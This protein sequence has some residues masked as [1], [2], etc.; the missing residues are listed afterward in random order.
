MLSTRHPMDGFSADRVTAI[1]ANLLI[2]WARSAE[3]HCTALEKQILQGLESIWRRSVQ[4]QDHGGGGPPPA[5][6]PTPR[7]PRFPPGRRPP[8]WFGGWWLR[9]PHSRR[10]E[11]LP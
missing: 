6:G 4:F 5:R 10:R 2:G 9:Q 1:E 11:S 8:A 7:P 3:G